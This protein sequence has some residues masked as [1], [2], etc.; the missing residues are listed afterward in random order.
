ME[1]GERREGGR[2]DSVSPLRREPE[3]LY[4]PLPLSLEVW[5][6]L[7]LEVDCESTGVE[8]GDILSL[9]PSPLTME[10]ISVSSAP[11]CDEVLGG[12]RRC[13]VCVY[14]VEDTLV[15]TKSCSTG[16]SLTAAKDTRRSGHSTSRLDWYLCHAV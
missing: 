10:L 14:S 3:V 12:K 9:S 2:R 5:G 6:E 15:N 4:F 1:E 7:E 8:R 11:A 16:L 13:V